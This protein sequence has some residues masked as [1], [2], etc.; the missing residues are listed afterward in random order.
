MAKKQQH[1][2]T[3]QHEQTG[4]EE[5]AEEGEGGKEE[6]EE[7][8]EARKVEVPDWRNGV[9]VEFKGVDSNGKQ[10]CWQRL[11]NSEYMRL[12]SSWMDG[13]EKA[14]REETEGGERW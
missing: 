3:P 10:K 11:T 8:E 4:E 9:L 12:V 6:E 5:D 7:E 14:R 13:W 2:H 1:Q